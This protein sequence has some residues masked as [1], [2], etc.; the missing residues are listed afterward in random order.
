MY[1]E[2]E[3]YLI[4]VGALCERYNPDIDRTISVIGSINDSDIGYIREVRFEETLG[5]YEKKHWRVMALMV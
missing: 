5:A 2:A 1:R 4:N 3:G